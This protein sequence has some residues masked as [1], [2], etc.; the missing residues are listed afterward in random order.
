MIITY[1]PLLVGALVNTE[2]D[3]LLRIRANWGRSG[4]LNSDDQFSILMGNTV[5]LILVLLPFAVSYL[6][7]R[8]KGLLYLS[9][10]Q[11]KVF[12]KRWGL[13]FISFR[14]GHLYFYLV[15][16]AR[17]SIFVIIAFY[18]HETQFT[19]FQ[20]ASNLNLSLWF[21]NYVAAYKPF[22]SAQMN[23]I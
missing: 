21:C 5:Y 2:N 10:N 19:F 17:K 11:R 16:I 4:H 15:L 3:Y 22:K 8:K 1:L 9:N 23:R 13:L 6:I 18:Y 20:I 7:W 12:E 14:P